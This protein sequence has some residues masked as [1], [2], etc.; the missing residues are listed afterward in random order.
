M[1]TYTVEIESAFEGGRSKYLSITT[2]L[3]GRGAYEFGDAYP[4]A[5]AIANYYAGEYCDSGSVYVR[6]GADSRY[7]ASA[8]RVCRRTID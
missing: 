4:N 1:S 6:R 2:P 8:G 7:G 5:Q 3:D